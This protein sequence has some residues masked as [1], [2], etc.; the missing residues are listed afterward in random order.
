MEHSFEIYN[1]PK[2]E[3][4]EAV[5]N[6]AG[7]REHIIQIFIRCLSKLHKKEESESAESI[8]NIA[9]TVEDKLFRTANSRL[10]YYKMAAIKLREFE[11]ENCGEIDSKIKGKQ[12]TGLNMKQELAALAEKFKVFNI[13]EN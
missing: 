10:E 6:A 4:W 8:K 1:T 5:V 3:N 9:R 2:E 11:L 13:I 12:E 7:M